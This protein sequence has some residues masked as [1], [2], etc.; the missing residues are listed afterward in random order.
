MDRRLFL[1]LLGAALATPVALAPDT[2]LGEAAVEVFP[3][4]PKEMCGAINWL[5]SAV[6]SGEFAAFYED[7]RQELIASARKHLPEGRRFEIRQRAPY[8]FGRSL[9]M[10]WYSHVDM[11][12]VPDWDVGLV[13]PTR[14]IPEGGYYLAANQVA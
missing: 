3:H 5:Q 7:V 2:A 4:H 13:V 14:W 9:G 6:P 11:Q 10:A 8:D 1:K 12:D